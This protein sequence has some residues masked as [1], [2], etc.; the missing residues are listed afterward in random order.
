M[1][2][3]VVAAHP[4]PTPLGRPP[5]SHDQTSDPSLLSQ[6]T[7][8][9]QTFVDQQ[10]QHRDSESSQPTEQSMSQVVDTDF[11]GQAYGQSSISQTLTNDSLFQSSVEEQTSQLSSHSVMG[12]TDPSFDIPSSSIPMAPGQTQVRSGVYLKSTWINTF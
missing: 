3:A 8:S 7:F 5:S 1:D 12:Q 9:S 4:M 6:Q 11:V 10:R 2:P